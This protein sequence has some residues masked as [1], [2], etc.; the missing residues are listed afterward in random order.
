MDEND[1]DFLNPLVIKVLV[2][3]LAVVLARVL[4]KVFKTSLEDH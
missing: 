1:D 4:F 3:E 2:H